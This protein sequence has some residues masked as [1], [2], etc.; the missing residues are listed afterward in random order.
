[1]KV[2]PLPSVSD[3]VKVNI[4][5]VKVPAEFV[6]ASVVAS[7]DLVMLAPPSVTVKPPAVI[8]APP[9]STFNPPDVIVDGHRGG[10]HHAATL[11]TDVGVAPALA[12]MKVNPLPSVSDEVKVNIVVV[13]VPAEF[14]SASVVASVDLV[15][16]AP[17]SVTVKPP[18]VIVAPPFSTF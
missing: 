9:F 16:L 11:K 12:S 3:E 5:V 8:V 2:N 17:P 13:K 14:V 6:S 1:M 4:V 18:A 7:V 15:M 10:R